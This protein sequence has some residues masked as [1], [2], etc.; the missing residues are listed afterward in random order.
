MDEIDVCDGECKPGCDCNDG[1]V[2]SRGGYCVRAEYC[3]WCECFCLKEQNLLSLVQCSFYTIFILYN[4][5]ILLTKIYKI[6][7]MAMIN[8]ECLKSSFYKT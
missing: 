6:F 5:C 3:H 2:R 1:Y 4:L 8:F 7:I